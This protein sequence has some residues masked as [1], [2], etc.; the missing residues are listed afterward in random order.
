MRYKRTLDDKQGHFS[1]NFPDSL[2][3]VNLMWA[4]NAFTFFLL[5]VAAR[6]APWS[7]LKQHDLLHVFFGFVVSLML[8]WSVKAGI[9]PGL[10][11]HLLGATVLTLMFGW[12]LALIALLLVLL[13]ITLFGMAG[14]EALGLNFMMM[15]AIPVIF[16]YI[17][18]R[19][20]DRKLPNHLFIYI[21][22]SSFACAAIAITLCGFFSTFIL[23]ESGVYPLSYLRQNYLAY[24]I[25]MAWSEA[26]LT[27][28]AVT[29]MTAFRPH[30]L[31]TFSDERYLKIRR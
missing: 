23:S 31:M 12:Q 2:L 4:A 26:L 20:V 1:M 17:L 25:F 29:L 15:V 27:G 28:M 11:F 3:P 16:S 19:W 9:R 18:F 21:F 5:V 6:T 7:H 22:I 24:Y 30:W 8:I 13:C 10:N 14:W